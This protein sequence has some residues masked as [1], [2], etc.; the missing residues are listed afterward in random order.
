MPVYLFLMIARFVSF[1]LLGFLIRIVGDIVSHILLGK[2]P[3]RGR[4]LTSN[5]LLRKKE[6][7]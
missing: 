1:I 7:H 3:Y 5:K 2:K 6:K 4:N